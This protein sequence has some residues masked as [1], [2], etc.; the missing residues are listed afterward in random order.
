MIVIC[1][2]DIEFGQRLIA[3]VCTSENMKESQLRNWHSERLQRFQMPKSIYFV[4]EIPKNEIGKIKK[5]TLL[6]ML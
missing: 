4:S 1:I 3:F 2:S 6:E 5:N